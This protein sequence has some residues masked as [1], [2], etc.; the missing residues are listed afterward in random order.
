MSERQRPTEQTT[1]LP[2]L[3]PEIW[4]VIAHTSFKYPKISKYARAKLKG[5]IRDEEGPYLGRRHSKELDRRFYRLILMYWNSLIG[6]AITRNN[7]RLVQRYFRLKDKE[8]PYGLVTNSTLDDYYYADLPIKWSAEKSRHNTNPYRWSRFK[9]TWFDVEHHSEGGREE[10]VF[11]GDTYARGEAAR[12]WT[13]EKILE[14]P[15]NLREL[16]LL[17]ES[18]GDITHKSPSQLLMMVHLVPEDI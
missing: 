7:N 18:A 5:L 11:M 9:R 17:D 1:E 13:T 4:E 16:F 15:R 6:P 10:H 14:S 2:E 12:R 8:F 3:P